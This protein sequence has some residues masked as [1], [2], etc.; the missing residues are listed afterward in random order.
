MGNWGAVGTVVAGAVG[1]AEAGNEGVEDEV[2]CAGF[3]EEEGLSGNK[4]TL[5]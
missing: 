2:D 3:V 4:Y 5:F 1:A